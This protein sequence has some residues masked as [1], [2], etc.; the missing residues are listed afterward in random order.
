VRYQQ[1]LLVVLKLFLKL[2][3]RNL[4]INCFACLIV[5]KDRV[6]ARASSEKFLLFSIPNVLP[7]RIVTVHVLNAQFESVSQAPTMVIMLIILVAV[8]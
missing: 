7:V 5:G 2:G 4:N 6:L 1:R 3:V 8:F